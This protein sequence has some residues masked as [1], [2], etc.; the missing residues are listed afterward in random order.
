HYC[1][2]LALTRASLLLTVSDYSRQKIAQHSNFS[3]ERIWI[4]P[5]AP[6]PVIRRIEDPTVLA[7]VCQRHGLSQPFVLADALKNPGVLVEAWRR[8]PPEIRKDKKIVF[9]SRRLDLLPIVHEA[10]TNGDAQL[11]LR[12]STEDLVALYSSAEAFVFPSFFEGF[13]LPAIE[14]MT[15]GAPVIASN[16]GSIPEVVGD[17]ALLADATD[18]ATLARHLALVLGDR[19]AAQKLREK[20]FARAAEFSWRRSA[21]RILESYEAVVAAK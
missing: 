5:N 4:V 17:A 21:Q 2:R 3:A 7:E 20:G 13:G 18:A 12:P 6:A 9:F 16:R 14:A 15:C 1:S 11:L 19:C 8:L 10:V